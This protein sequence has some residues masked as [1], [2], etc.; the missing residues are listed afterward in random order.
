M[1]S[2]IVTSAFRFGS[3]SS[4]TNSEKSTC[5]NDNWFWTGDGDRMAQKYT[6]R[7]RLLFGAIM[8]FGGPEKRNVVILGKVGSGKKTLANRIAGEALFHHNGVLGVSNAGHQ[9][10]NCNVEGRP[11]HILIVDTEGLQTGY[12]DPM[13]PCISV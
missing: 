13:G 9:S 1:N 7:V 8:S 5:A 3:G 10:A 2:E 11:Y 6:D 4:K 12:Q